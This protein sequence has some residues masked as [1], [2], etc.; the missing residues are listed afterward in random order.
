[1]SIANRQQALIDD[2][3]IIEN[4][5]ERLGAV[6]DAAR[7]RPRF[8]EDERTDDRLVSGCQSRVWLIAE[9]DGTT[10]RFRSDCDSPMVA[11]LVALQLAPYDGAA[12]ADILATPPHV[13]EELGLL[14]DL[15]PTRR[16]G[17]AAVHARV[18]AFAREV[19]GT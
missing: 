19:G 18:E 4:H 6:V 12:P 8:S 7:E 11:G 1:M 17:L 15:T 2:Y 3:A 9:Y 16:N 10:C 14:R 13:L 5:H